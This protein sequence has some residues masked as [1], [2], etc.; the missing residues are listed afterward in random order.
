MAINPLI[1]LQVKPLNLDFTD[2][3]LR[4]AHSDLYEQQAEV[5][6]QNIEQ[7]K[8]TMEALKQFGNDITPDT[9]KQVMRTN[10][11]A[12]MGMQTVLSKQQADALALEKAGFEA[13]ESAVK[14]K[15][16]SYKQKKDELEGW[17]N[18]AS[19]ITD[20]QSYYQALRMGLDRGLDPS[21]VRGMMDG[22]YDPAKV[23]QFA[24]QMMTGKERLELEDAL[25]KKAFE[26]KK[27]PL[28]LKKAEGEAVNVTRDETG[29]T[30]GE[31]V[32]DNR[33]AAQRLFDE[34]KI[35]QQQDFQAQQNEENR[36]VQRRGQ[37][38]VDARSRDAAASD[39]DALVQAVLKDPLAFDN[40]TP[41]AKTRIIP[42]LQRNGFDQFGKP[43][44]AGS[45]DKMA[46]SS[47]A[48]ASLQD[49]RKTLQ[50]NEQFIG[51]IAGF[52][53]INPYSDA[54]K[55]QAKID[56]VKQRVGKALE[57]GVLRKEDEEKYKKILATLN[58][59]PETAI[60]KVDGL[61]AT[62]ER[63]AKI[64]QDQ[65]RAAGRRMP[66][67]AKPA[68]GAKPKIKILKVE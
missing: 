59:T 60:A 5:Q 49:L 38:M 3:R 24:K 22:G 36:K 14:A 35:K 55:A 40:L 42:A 13:E 19:G 32:L 1:A 20:E 25:E 31:V 23:N 2:R 51:P 27:R 12:A 10:P 8:A 56:L 63:D 64:Y 26:A 53:A 50:E 11:K 66:T 15:S 43:L 21:L 57:G 30:P 48:V 28:E 4:N 45:I 67:Q 41:T 52:A 68:D 16:A 18:L 33:T 6:R 61:I 7:E 46:E 58:D 39:D 17:A 37:N 44:N 34:Q 62:L 29:R 65:Q 54:R 47:A 9:I